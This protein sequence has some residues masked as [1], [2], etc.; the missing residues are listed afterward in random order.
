M[1]NKQLFMGTLSGI[2]AA[3]ALL[4]PGLTYGAN[5]Q[6]TEMSATSLGRAHSGGAAQAEDASAIWYNPAGLENLNGSE[7]LGGYALIRFGADF[8]KTSATDALGDPLTGGNG[9]SVG[10]LGGPLFVYYSKQLSDKL[11]FGFGLNTP[12]GL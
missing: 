3:M 8:T 4:L 5:F 9:G 2:A 10:K 12:F 7:I 1:N 6:L 11:S